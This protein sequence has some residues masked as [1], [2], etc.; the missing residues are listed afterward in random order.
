LHQK[1]TRADDVTSVSVC[2]KA[3]LLHTPREGY[4]LGYSVSL[5]HTNQWSAT[6][7]HYCTTIYAL[8][9]KLLRALR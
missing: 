5:T 1:V 2:V 4:K 7:R 8:G 3:W 6:S 9:I